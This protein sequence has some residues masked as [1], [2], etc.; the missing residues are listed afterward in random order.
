MRFA[1]FFGCMH[2]DFIYACGFL[3]MIQRITYLDQF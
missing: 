3:P 1:W 2:A